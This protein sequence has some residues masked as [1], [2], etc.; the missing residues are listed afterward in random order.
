M[1]GVALLLEEEEGVSLTFGTIT[2]RLTPTITI[3]F[4]DK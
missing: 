3:T 2:M 1:E 4:M